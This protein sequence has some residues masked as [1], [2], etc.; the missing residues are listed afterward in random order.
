MQ[1]PGL[2]GTASG[3][4]SY[5]EELALAAPVDPALALAGL[6]DLPFFPVSCHPRPFL[7]VCLGFFVWLVWVGSQ[8]P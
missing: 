3:S 8:V 6:C 2:W 5:G 1:G 7:L 4:F